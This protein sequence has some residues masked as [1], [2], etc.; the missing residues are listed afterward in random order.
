MIYQNMQGKIETYKSENSSLKSQ[1]DSLKN[2]SFSFSKRQNP[3]TFETPV[4]MNSLGESDSLRYSTPRNPLRPL[5]PNA[6]TKSFKKPFEHE[7]FN[8]FFKK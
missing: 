4:N 8:S 7:G 2:S 5:M 6:S 1:L 3:F